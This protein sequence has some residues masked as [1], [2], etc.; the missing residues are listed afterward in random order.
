MQVS[1]A[2]AAGLNTWLIIDYLV[3]WLTNGTIAL[4]R[5]QLHVGL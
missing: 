2:H 3:Q 5:T 1:W 4:N